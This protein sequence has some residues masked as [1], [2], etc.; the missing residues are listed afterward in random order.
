LTRAPFIFLTAFVCCAALAQTSA[1]PGAAPSNCPVGFEHIDLRYNHAGGESVPQLRLAFT[2]R[3][4]KTITGFVFA[5]SI[6]D[7]QGNPAPYPTQFEYRR[8]FPIGEPQ[9]SRTWNLDR[10]SVDMHRSGESATLIEA[11]FSDGTAWKDDGSRACTLAFDYHA[12]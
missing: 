5:L 3:S 9:R 1:S 8:E 7:S 6:L 12:R 10:A 11:A 2:N 4:N